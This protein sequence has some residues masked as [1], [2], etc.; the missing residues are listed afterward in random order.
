MMWGVISLGSLLA[1]GATALVGLTGSLW[2]GALGTVLCLPMLL[3]RGMRGAVFAPAAA[4]PADKE[5][6][7]VRTGN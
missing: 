4:T 2:I 5:S 3:R 1:S 7:D 6:N